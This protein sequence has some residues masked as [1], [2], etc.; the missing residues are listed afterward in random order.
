MFSFLSLQKIICVNS[1]LEGKI[2][3]GGIMG[4]DFFIFTQGVEVFE[5]SDFEYEAASVII[6]DQDCL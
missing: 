1:F 4:D 2:K 3:N 6:I 5:T